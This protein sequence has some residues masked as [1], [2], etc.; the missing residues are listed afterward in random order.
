MINNYITVSIIYMYSVYS[1][2]TMFI[3]YTYALYTH[4]HMHT[5]THTHT[6]KT[7]YG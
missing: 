1:L 5:H 4:T 2:C 7:D 3:I 6:E